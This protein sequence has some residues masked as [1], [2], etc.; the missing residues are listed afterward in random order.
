[1]K[2]SMSLSK[3]CRM[4]LLHMIFLVRFDLVSKIKIVNQIKL[5]GWVKKSFEY[6]R[7]N[8]GF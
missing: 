4:H 2:K 5:C 6:I 8:C 3:V 1:M 7:C